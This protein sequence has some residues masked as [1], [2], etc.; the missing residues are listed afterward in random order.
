MRR[1]LVTVRR[2]RIY[3]FVAGV[4]EDERCWRGELADF[5]LNTY[6]NLS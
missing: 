2:N 5:E 1:E 3:I 4:C 6:M